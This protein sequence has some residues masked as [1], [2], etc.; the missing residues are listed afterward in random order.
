MEGGDDED[1]AGSDAWNSQDDRD[2]EEEVYLGGG[3]LGSPSKLNKKTKKTLYGLPDENA[4]D[5]DPSPSSNDDDDESSPE[6]DDD[7][8]QASTSKSHHLHPPSRSTID[9]PPHLLSLLSLR[10]PESQALKLHQRRAQ[11]FQ[12]IFAPP[13]PALSSARPPPPP[14]VPTRKKSSKGKEK[15]KEVVAPLP[16]IKRRNLDGKGKGGEVWGIGDEIEVA[17][18][19]DDDWASE[20]EGW[21]EGGGG[22]ERE[23]EDW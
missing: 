8:S 16:V 11:T 6:N 23:E 2:L 17:G 7:P 18:D 4:S 21:K 20:V 15:E 10:S 14:P 3:G 19:E 13:P 12:S 1:G 9:L 5:S 22:L